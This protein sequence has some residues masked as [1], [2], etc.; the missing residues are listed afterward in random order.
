M[1]RLL[2]IAIAAFMLLLPLSLDAK[3]PYGER[4][5]FN[6]NEV[7]LGGG[8]FYDGYHYKSVKL[9]SYMFGRHLDDRWFIGASAVCTLSPIYAGY[10]YYGERIYDDSFGFRV[11]LNGRYNILKK[12]VSPY[13]GLD[14]G[15]GYIPGYSDFISPYAGAQLGV[16][17]IINTHKV[18]GFHVEPGITIKGYSEILFKL[19][20]EFI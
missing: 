14:I 15:G 18:L 9:A 17:W 3:R 13:V 7:A 12:K 10:M 5:G 16:R 20:F 1:K 4:V 11:L 2:H 19:T 6:V 8:F